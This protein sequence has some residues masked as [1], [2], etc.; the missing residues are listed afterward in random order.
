MITGIMTKQ[1]LEAAVAEGQN[2][3][4]ATLREANLSEANLREANLRG[5]YLRGANLSGA[6]LSEADLTNAKLP[7]FQ[8]PEGPLEVW[9]S[10]NGALVKLL[11][12]RNARRTASLVGRKCRAE[13]AEVLEVEGGTDPTTSIESF[14][15]LEYRP[16]ATVHPDSYDDDIRVE[17]TNGIHFF[18]TKQEAKD[19]GF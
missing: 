9:K 19:S 17:C 10:C 4:G 16:G 11:I 14:R 12:P 13:F 15:G 1:Q 7:Y 5:A 3:R 6:Y 8:I 18:Q 2:L